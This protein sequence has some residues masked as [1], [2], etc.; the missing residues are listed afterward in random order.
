MNVE[1]I[2]PFLIECQNIFKEVG[3]IE[4]SLVGTTLKRN[5]FATKNVVVMVGV[6]G[7]LKGSV[8]INMDKELAMLIA[9]NMMYGMEVKELDEL[10]KSAVSELGNMT[11]GKVASAF[12]S[13][14]I[15][16][17]ITPPT[18]MIGESIELTMPNVPLLSIKFKYDKFDIDVDI[19]IIKEV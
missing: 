13:K 14:G 1:H 15:L 9:S 11:M 5:P 4:L 19:S 17:D 10:S 6:T 18:L 12:Y 16:I 7:Q 8:V 2:N 3:G